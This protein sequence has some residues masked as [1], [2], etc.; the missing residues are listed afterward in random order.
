MK[1]QAKKISSSNDKDLC[2]SIKEKFVKQ[3]TF[4]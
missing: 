4:N 3:N 1:Y 2:G